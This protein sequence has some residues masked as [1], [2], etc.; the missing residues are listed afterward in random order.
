MQMRKKIGQNKTRNFPLQFAEKVEEVTYL[1]EVVV[2][3]VVQRHNVVV[4]V[5]ELL[6]FYDIEAPMF[7]YPWNIFHLSHHY[8]YFRRFPLYDDVKIGRKLFVALE[9]DIYDEH[10]QGKLG[11]IVLIALTCQNGTTR[12]TLAAE[13]S[14]KIQR[15]RRMRT[16]LSWLGQKID[17]VVVEV[18]VLCQQRMIVLHYLGKKMTGGFVIEVG[19]AHFLQDHDL[20]ASD[21]IYQKNFR[22]QQQ[23]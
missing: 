3:E 6:R 1:D 17:F 15:D 23:F 18:E 22:F 12:Q 13:K 5:V 4:E 20:D 8:Y 7:V 21:H 11:Q 9:L 10:G 19:D 2:A 16:D 14:L